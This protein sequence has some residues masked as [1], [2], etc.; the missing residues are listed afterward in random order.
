MKKPEMIIFDY[1]QTLLY[2]PGFDALKGEEAL[3]KYIKTNKNNLTPVDINSF[4]Q[5]AFAQLMAVRKIGYE[6]HEWQFLKYVYEYLNIELTISIEE[7]EKILWYNMSPGALMPGIEYMLDDINARGIR[8][9]VISNIGW[10]GS[11]LKHRIDRLLPNNQFEFIMA[12]SDYVFRKPDRRLFELALRKAGITADS[13][14]YCGDNVKADVEGAAGAGIYPVWYEEMTV[15]NP[16]RGENTEPPRCEHLH[17]H[18]WNEL[19]E[20][21]ESL[22]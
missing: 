1:G 7:A 17:I 20:L 18:H 5:E 2:E 4:E 11:A 21:L 16:W 12:S 19:N 10:S 6:I 14:W 8:S 15:E 3:F 13:V 22:K 9:G